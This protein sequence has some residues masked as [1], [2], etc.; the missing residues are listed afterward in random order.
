MR[1]AVLSHLSA[2]LHG[3]SEHV[4]SLVSHPRLGL[5]DTKIQNT[6]QNNVYRVFAISHSHTSAAHGSWTK[7][8]NHR[9]RAQRMRRRINWHVL[10]ID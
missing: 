9:A 5:D 3:R 8:C 4:L 10:L 7:E 1:R 6:K 2:R